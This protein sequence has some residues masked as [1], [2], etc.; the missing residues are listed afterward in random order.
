[1]KEATNMDH[2]IHDLLEFARLGRSELRKQPVR[3]RELVMKV[4]AEF[5]G[6]TAN[7][8]VVWKI[9]DLGEV[10][11][12]PNLLRYALVNLIDNALKYTRGR[13]EARIKIDASPNGSDDDTAVLFV[14]DNGCGFEMHRAKKL[15][16]PFE[17][18]H[19]EHD[20]EGTGMGLANVQRIIQRHGGRIWCESE[21]AKGATFYFTL[22]RSRVKALAS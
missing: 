21:P 3:M 22:S 18:L 19:K 6:Q 5:R 17:R 2:L 11:G 14:Q 15:F 20:F 7:R 8:N 12:D 9:G 13:A 10:Y 4:I 16:N 1:M